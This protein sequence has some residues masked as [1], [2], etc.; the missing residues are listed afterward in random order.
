MDNKYPKLEKILTTIF[1]KLR[2]QAFSKYVQPDS[3]YM[4]LVEKANQAEQTCMESDLTEKQAKLVEE[5]IS[6]MCEASDRELCLT[7]IAGFADCLFF[8][9]EYGFLTNADM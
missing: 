9:D 5:M 2:H 6:K 8:L 3:I 7:Y 1:S 4:E